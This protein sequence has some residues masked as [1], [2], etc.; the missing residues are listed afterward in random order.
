MKPNF[1]AAANMPE[2]SN[3]AFVTIHHDF[4]SPLMVAV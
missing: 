3:E 1:E 2:P 4:K